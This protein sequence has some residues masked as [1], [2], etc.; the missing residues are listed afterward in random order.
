MNAAIEGSGAGYGAYAENGVYINGG[1]ITMN[2]AAL[3]GYER[4]VTVTPPEGY[5]ITVK[6]GES[7]EKTNTYTYTETETVDSEIRSSEYFH[8]EVIENTVEVRNPNI[9]IGGVAMYGASDS[10]AYAT[11]DESGTVTEIT[12]ED[13][14]P[15]RTAGTSNGMAPP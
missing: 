11:T 6:Y 14:T 3:Y 9:T 2:S 12:G 1:T 10:V 8:S 15:T 7:S 4:G 5:Y 13:L